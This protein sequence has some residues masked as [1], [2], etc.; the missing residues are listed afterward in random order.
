M[1]F[2]L[3]LTLIFACSFICFSQ[4]LQPGLYAEIKTPKGKIT[5]WLEFEKVPLTV[6][7]FVAL[8]EGKMPNGARPPGKPFYDGLKFHR[9]VKNFMIQG[10]APENAGLGYTF[11]DE[12]NPDLMTDRAGVLAM[13]NAGPD[14]NECQFFITHVA[15]P[16]LFNKHSV[17]GNVVEGQ[18]V[19]DAIV[20]DDVIESI[21]II[22]VGEKAKRFDAL[23][24]FNELNGKK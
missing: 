11:R 15:T 2:F 21:K 22:R 4:T 23:R 5:L 24:T 18:D 3:F 8:A 13:A 6:A 14:T 20:Q 17:F 9:V 16:W 19:V 12:F 1:K 10:G 7:N